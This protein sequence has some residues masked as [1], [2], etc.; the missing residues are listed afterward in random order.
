MRR[1]R[2]GRERER[3]TKRE[4]KWRLKDCY[5]KRAPMQQISTKRQKMQKT[6]H[7]HVIKLKTK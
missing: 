2:R 5:T 6:E 3:E 1:R 4:R 7:L